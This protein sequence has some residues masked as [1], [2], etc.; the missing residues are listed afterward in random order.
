MVTVAQLAKMI[1]HSILQ[2]TFTDQDLRK[3]CEIAVKY[4]VASVCVK[5]YATRMAADLVK[6]T[7]VK[8][9]AVIGFP[10]GNSA[11]EVKVYETEQVCRDGATEVDMVVNI[12]KVLQQDWT[13]IEIELKAVHDA[14]LRNKSILKVIFETDFVTQDELKIK[15]CEL[16]SALK[17]EFVKTSTGYGFVKGA[18]GK[19]TYQGATEH[20]LKLMRLHCAPQVQVKASGGIRTLDQLLQ[21]REWGV[22]RI[23][24]TATETM[25]EEAKKRFALK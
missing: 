15:L 5:P 11:T 8:V 6:G 17:I 23:G 22:T 20:D 9:C 18:D 13:F 16:A 25:L 3:Q 1:D 10:H 12:G 24:A 7:D 14:C 2:P 4:D 21:V 19:Y